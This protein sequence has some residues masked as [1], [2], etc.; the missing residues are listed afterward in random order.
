VK[1]KE[2]GENLENV[3]QEL[4][5]R[6]NGQHPALSQ[7]P[8]CFQLLTINGIFENHLEGREKEGLEGIHRT[9][10]G[11]GDEPASFIVV[12][13]FCDKRARVQQGSSLDKGANGLKEVVVEL[14][15]ARVLA[16][17][18]HDLGELLQGWLR[19]G[20]H[21]LFAGTDDSH[22]GC[23]VNR[24]QQSGGCSIMKKK[25]RRKEKEKEIKEDFALPFIT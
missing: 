6:N 5:R 4:C 19:V 13:Q 10:V 22:D 16:D 3:G 9:G 20:T 23:K 17:D 25:R 11:G 24:N 14:G 7:N 18:E 2:L 1:L 8:P 12:G 15:V 21:L